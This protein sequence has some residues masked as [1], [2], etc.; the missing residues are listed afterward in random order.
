MLSLAHALAVAL[1]SSPLPSTSSRSVIRTLPVARSEVPHPLF[2]Q[3]RMQTLA[4]SR[5]PPSLL[6][7][8]PS[9][10]SP[11]APWVG[12]SDVAARVLNTSG[13]RESSFSFCGT[14]YFTRIKLLSS[15][16]S[17]FHRSVGAATEAYARTGAM[18]RGVPAGLLM[19]SPSSG[20]R[21]P[22]DPHT[23]LQHE[24]CPR[25]CAQPSADAC[26]RRRLYGA[27]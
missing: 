18:W 8:V 14:L 9:A 7:V 27:V 26:H 10:A 15:L 2:P 12:S 11:H 16:V 3:V 4:L 1:C 21:R 22:R 5:P 24:P 19:A 20:Q 25:C 6:T 17:A 23:Q 13:I